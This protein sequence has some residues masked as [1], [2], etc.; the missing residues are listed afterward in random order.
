VAA[1]ARAEEAILVDKVVAVVGNVAILRSDVVATVQ[2]S[3]PRPPKYPSELARVEKEVL[4]LLVDNAL[5]VRDALRRGLQVSDLEVAQAKESIAQNVGRT[6]D[7]LVDDVTRHGF[8]VR[9][10]DSALRAE[11]L[12]QKWMALVVNPRVRVTATPE[13]MLNP[14]GPYARELIA[15]RSRALTELRKW[16]FVEIR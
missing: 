3:R 4:E 16:A 11:I 2:S 6:H 15:E 13:E 9:A 14:E 10:Y 5:I 12:K 7:D 1:P 8:S